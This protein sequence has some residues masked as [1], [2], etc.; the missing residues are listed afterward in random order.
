MIDAFLM[1]TWAELVPDEKWPLRGQQRHG[2]EEGAGGEQG[3]GAER[4]RK[5]L[6]YLPGGMGSS[7]SASR[8]WEHIKAE[9]TGKDRG[10]DAC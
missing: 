9:E 5:V 3:S 10:T 4:K 6:V 8:C 2:E 7:F 1:L